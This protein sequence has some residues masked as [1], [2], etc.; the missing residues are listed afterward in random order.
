MTS[1][2]YYVHS[3]ADFDN[4]FINRRGSINLGISRMSFTF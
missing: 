3:L 4:T 2:S 1:I